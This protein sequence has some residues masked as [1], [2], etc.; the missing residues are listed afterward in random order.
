MVSGFDLA[1]PLYDNLFTHSLVGRYQRKAV[2][3]VLDSYLNADAPM[4]ILELNCGTGEDAMYMAQKGHSVLA[5]DRSAEMLNIA[6]TKF[7]SDLELSL[8]QLDI[9]ALGSLSS[10]NK[11]HLLFSN[12]GGLNCISPRQF[13]NFIEA[14]SEQLL[15]N[16]LLIA[17][18]MPKKCL[19][20]RFY[21]L[22]KGKTKEVYRRSTK[23]PV[24]VLVEGV[25]VPTWYYDPPELLNFSKNVFKKLAVRPIGFAVPPSY[26]NSFFMNK[27]RLLKFLAWTDK[28]PFRASGFSAYSDHYIIVL[29]KT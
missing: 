26:L 6:R 4:R 3:R 13:L 16:G 29:Q 9:E 10:S 7:R 23:G 11:F 12:F 18:V 15:P 14:S 17:V 27:K 20:D 1:A 28:Y 24:E 22:A 19:W 21:L 2:Y 25:K 5:T 8:A